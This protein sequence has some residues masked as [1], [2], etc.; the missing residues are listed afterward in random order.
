MQNFRY[1]LDIQMEMLEE[2][3]IRKEVPGMYI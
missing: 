3:Q 1:L 2:Q